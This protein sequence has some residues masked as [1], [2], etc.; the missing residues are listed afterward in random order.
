MFVTAHA[1]TTTYLDQRLTGY[2]KISFDVLQVLTALSEVPGG[3][4]RMSELANQ[5]LFS[6][7]GLTRMI[8]RLE[9]QGLVKRIP[10]PDDR[11][12]WF[13]AITEKGESALKDAESIYKPVLQEV[14]VDALSDQEA[15]QLMQS[16][17]KVLK[18]ASLARASII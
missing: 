16:F 2:G 8:D 12:G 14:W 10:C 13:A 5:I 15:D 17:G 7:S 4:M 3:K 11:R 9:N 1:V 6:R 18:S